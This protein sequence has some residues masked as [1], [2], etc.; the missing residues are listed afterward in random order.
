MRARLAKRIALAS[1]VL[2]LAIWAGITLNS[3][4]PITMTLRGFVTNSFLIPRADGT[5]NYAYAIIEITNRSSK[6]FQCS[7][8]DYWSQQAVRDVGISLW[9]FSQRTLAPHGSF[10]LQAFAFG[11]YT[12]KI[13]LIFTPA[14]KPW[15]Y[16]HFPNAVLR[17][18]PTNLHTPQPLKVSTPYFYIP[19]SPH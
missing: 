13:E 5:T 10:K 9:G 12:N 16:R 17:A 18:I 1:A 8:Q 2:A 3:G 15:P 6:S 14:Q 19:K 7:A 11:G 4:P